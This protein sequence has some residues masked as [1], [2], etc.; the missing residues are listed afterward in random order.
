MRHIG[1]MSIIAVWVAVAAGVAQS[2]TITVDE[3]GNGSFGTAPLPGSLLPD[4]TGATTLP[5]LTYV[6]P[7][8]VVP[9]VIRLDESADPDQGGSDLL[10]FTDL[11]ALNGTVNSV[12]RSALIFLSD[13]ESGSEAPDLADMPV[14]LRGIITPS[15]VFVEQGPATGPNGFAY[16]PGANDPGFAQGVDYNFVSDAAPVPATASA[17]GGLVLLGGF[18]LWKLIRRNTPAASV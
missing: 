3:N 8:H 18:G 5:L 14:V 12:P 17:W 16:T 9:G 11:P 4:A 15:K 10:I 2:A 6:L 7:V 13:P 1:F